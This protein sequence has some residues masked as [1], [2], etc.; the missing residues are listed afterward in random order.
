MSR[1]D[2]ELLD[3]I[4]NSLDQSVEQLDGSTRSR[5]A[6]AR[7]RALEGASP[8][9]NYWFA[10]GGFAT[11]SLLVAALLIYKPS[12]QGGEGFPLATLEDGQDLEIIAALEEPEL[13][14]DMEFYYWLEEGS[15]DAT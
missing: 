10:A 6:S 14:E 13:L 5:L 7:T 2:D 4:R 11:A 15:E 8:R 3:R 9:H 12:D 1:K